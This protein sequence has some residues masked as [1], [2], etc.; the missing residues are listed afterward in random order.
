MEIKFKE[1][2]ET[3]QKI[4]PKKVKILSYDEKSDNFTI[5]VGN[6]DKLKSYLENNEESLKISL[7]GDSL[8]FYEKEN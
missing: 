8:V 7:I 2:L 6:F 4:N 1:T 3:L 5:T